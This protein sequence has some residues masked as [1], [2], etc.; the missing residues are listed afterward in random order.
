MSV[1][2]EPT[3]A[4]PPFTSEDFARRMT[5][6]GAA[7]AAAGLDAVLITPGPDLVYMTGYA[8][9]A[10]TERM[11]LLVV[12]PQ[13]APALVVPELEKPD[14]EACA[15]AATLSIMTWA[16][17]ES[18]Y[19]TARVLV[20]ASGRFAI[21]DSAW[22][23]HLLGMQQAL[24]GS[25]YRSFSD[26]LPTLR[27]VKDRHELDRLQGAAHA[28]DAVFEEMRSVRLSGRSESDVGAELA[29][30]LRAHG[31][32]EVDFTVVGSGP[33]GANPHHEIGERVIQ[34]G[35]MVVLDFG[36]LMSG[37]GSDTTRTVCAGE[38]SAEEREVYEVVRVAQQAAFEAVRPGVPCQ[39]IDRAA[40]RVIADAG[41]GDYF[42]HRTGHSI[43]LRPMSRHIWWRA[44][45]SSSN[46][47]CASPSNPAC[48][49]PGGSASVSKT[50]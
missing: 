22:A 4:P 42:I 32:E 17:G 12:T 39:E 45:P 50:S 18:A 3:A 37:Y 13:G 10:I 1:V 25:H 33:N 20:P 24:P 11:T 7:A 8:P 46:P 35:D 23:L 48:T 21:S 40:R 29:R 41:Y 16:D 49:C 44:K 14:A 9:V 15:A 38:P 34:R 5:R 43:G 28:A 31:H 19:E 30:R 26:A 2:E 36:G 47:A 6:A 27:A